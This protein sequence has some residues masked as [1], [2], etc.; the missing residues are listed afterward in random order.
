MGRC[1]VTR[2]TRWVSAPRRR[3]DEEM[4][5]RW[6][7]VADVDDSLLMYMVA[8]EVDHSTRYLLNVSKVP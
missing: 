2:K 4:M 8:H 5:V 6:E 3:A 7:S 1:R